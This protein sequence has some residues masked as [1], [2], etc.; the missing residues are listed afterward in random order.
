MAASDTSCQ[1]GHK[2][3]FTSIVCSRS[4]R[5]QNLTREAVNFRFQPIKIARCSSTPS[6]YPKNIP[7]RPRVEYQTLDRECFM[8]PASK[9]NSWQGIECTCCSEPLLERFRGLNP[10]IPES[11]KCQI[12]KRESQANRHETDMKHLG[13]LL[14]QETQEKCHIKEDKP[15]KFYVT[16]EEGNQRLKG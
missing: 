9:T 6:L 11:K 7:T 3:R 14:E 15:T 10:V 16:V 1:S 13:V 2:K 4:P 5:S 8:C 12:L